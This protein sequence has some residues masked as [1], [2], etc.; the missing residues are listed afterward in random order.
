M[1]FHY[2]CNKCWYKHILP[3]FNC[4][5][6]LVVVIA[7]IKVIDSDGKRRCAVEPIGPDSAVM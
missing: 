4:L 1:S 6:F 3:S 7:N 5:T 2:Y